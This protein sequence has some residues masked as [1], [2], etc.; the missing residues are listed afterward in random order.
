[1]DLKDYTTKSIKE[2]NDLIKISHSNINATKSENYFIKPK[3]T[4]INEELYGLTPRRVREIDDSI[5]KQLRKISKFEYETCSNIYKRP[6]ESKSVNQRIKRVYINSKLIAK[7]KQSVIIP[8]SNYL[9]PMI[10]PKQIAKR[11]NILNLSCRDEEIK[12]NGKK[13]IIPFKAYDKS[14]LFLPILSPKSK[15]PNY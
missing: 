14:A 6:I 12:D 9:I 10:I 11:K 3:A 13:K 7:K 4:L 15:V 8:K 2:R 5:S 1:M